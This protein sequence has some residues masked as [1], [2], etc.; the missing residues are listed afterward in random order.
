M[1]F[2]FHSQ[3]PQFIEHI[4]EDALGPANNEGSLHCLCGQ[5]ILKLWKQ[6]TIKIQY[7]KAG[8]ESQPLVTVHWRIAGEPL[9]PF[10]VKI[11]ALKADKVSCAKCGR[12]LGHMGWNRRYIYIFNEML[13]VKA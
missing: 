4:T 10:T 13:E 9:D 1:F 12:E 3:N 8:F 7:T 2:S 5:L 6:D 11:D